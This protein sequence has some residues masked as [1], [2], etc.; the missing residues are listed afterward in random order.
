MSLLSQGPNNAALPGA[1]PALG[2]RV[3]GVTKRY[4]ALLALRNVSLTIAAGEFVAVHGPNG[5][6]KSTLIR[7]CAQAARPTSGTV[8]YATSEGALLEPSPAVR[9]RVGLVGHSTLAYDELTAAENLLFFA[10]LYS[11]ASGPGRCSELLEAV[12]LAARRH[13]L[14]RT[15][16]RGMR[17]RLSIARA[18]LAAPGLLLL[19]EPTTG[20]D[21][22]ALEWLA[23]C[24]RDLHGKGCTVVMSTHGSSDV[25]HLATRTVTLSAGAVQSDGAGCAPGSRP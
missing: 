8:R 2:V 21:Q 13:S 18:L 4:G 12:G 22:Q 3:E 5:S 9:A 11:V 14:V 10:R 19:D 23:A 6:G 15:F 16:S 17:Q 20:L 25:L 1:T 24:L 7:I